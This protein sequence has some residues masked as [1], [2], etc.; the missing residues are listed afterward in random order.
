MIKPEPKFRRVQPQ[1]RRG[2]LVDA[3]LRCLA[4]HG[5]AGVS[6]RRIAAEAGVSPG[7]INH[8]YAGI[9]ELIAAAYETASVDILDNILEH[10]ATAAGPRARLTAFFEASFAP[11]VFDPKLINIWVV[12]WSM[13]P[14]APAL[15]EIQKRTFSDYRA[16]LE[17]ELAALAGEE[18]FVDF[19][20]RRAALGLSSLLDGLWLDGGLNP[21]GF[22]PAEGVTVCEDW[23][24]GL[25]ARER[26]RRA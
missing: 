13:L 23:V 10:V 24:D 21:G 12:F 11:R 8:H 7:L 6:A 3:T 26:A 18:G 5:H 9:E 4:A 15:K 14:H 19:D 2:L 1:T 25:V 20:A 17:R 16:S 22:Q